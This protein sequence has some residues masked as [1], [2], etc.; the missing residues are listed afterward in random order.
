MTRGLVPAVLAGDGPLWAGVGVIAPDDV[1]G[2]RWLPKIDA[3]LPGQGPAPGQQGPR[4]PPTGAVP[5]AGAAEGCGTPE[6]KS[7]LL[8]FA[9]T[10]Q[11]AVWAPCGRA[12][13]T[14][15]SVFENKVFGVGGGVGAP[16]LAGEPGAVRGLVPLAGPGGPG[17]PGP[18]GVP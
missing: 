17:L 8:F 11:S 7:H 13:E 5:G 4:A 12:A 2:L 9:P 18:A 6:T 16:G 3:A 14:T 10:V 1:V 15:A